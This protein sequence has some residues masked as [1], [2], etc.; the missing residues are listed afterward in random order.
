M[1]MSQSSLLEQQSLEETFAQRASYKDLDEDDIQSLGQELPDVAEFRCPYCEYTHEKEYTVRAH[2]V[3]EKDADDHSNRNPF[4][5]SGKDGVNVHMLDA[6]GELLGHVAPPSMKK[7]PRGDEVI[8]ENGEFR[9]EYLPNSISPSASRQVEIVQT[10]LT[11]LDAFVNDQKGKNFIAK[12][13]YPNREPSEVPR[14]YVYRTLDEAFE[15]TGEQPDA[16]L[17]TESEE[18]KLD[19]LNDNQFEFLRHWAAAEL[20]D[21]D[22]SMSEIEDAAG[23]GSGYGS[24]LFGRHDGLKEEFLAQAKAGTI[25]V[26]AGFPP[27]TTDVEEP[28]T[29][30]SEEEEDA[31]WEAMYNDLSPVEGDIV[32]AAVEH[33]EWTN[34]Q[35]QAAVGCSESYPRQK[36]EEHSA[37]IEHLRTQK[38]AADATAPT[39]APT[40]EA[41]AATTTGMSASPEDSTTMSADTESGETTDLPD[42][43]TVE[44]L[45]DA[46]SGVEQGMSQSLDSIRSR[47]DEMSDR[48]EAVDERV[49]TLDNDRESVDELRSEV[50]DLRQ[51]IE[52]FEPSRPSGE[53][54]LD[55]SDDEAGAVI[56]SLA[57]N[58]EVSNELLVRVSTSL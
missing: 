47:I 44:E 16:D 36:R 33:P 54:T 3:A 26:G 50:A 23:R 32:D 58:N 56:R 19:S 31:D 48:V 52:N 34:S 25:D 27:D 14:S 11:N 2:V 29:T 21:E 43:D 18:S 8:D 49:D 9:M 35:I 12:Q 1:D 5:D 46:I 53:S 20:D 40:P 24:H 6:N 41:D 4:L 22:H 57:D 39:D 51:L 42:A 13:V 10:A 38:A 15:A 30:A 37:L 17:D 45:T 7:M 28:D 55:L